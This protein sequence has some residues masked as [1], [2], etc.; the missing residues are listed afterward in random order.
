MKGTIKLQ[1]LLGT[2]IFIT[3]SSLQDQPPS[4]LAKIKIWS[5]EAKESHQYH[6][7]KRSRQKRAWIVDAFEIQEELPGPYPKLIGTVNLEDGV[8]LR[9]K[10]QGKGINEEPKGL[11]HINED[12]GN[13]YVHD[14][15]DYEATPIFNW[16]F[17]AINRTSNKLG[18][19][20]GIQ[21][22]VI[23]INDNAPEFSSSSYEV[24]VNESCMQGFT[25]FTLL[26]YDKDDHFS[27]NSL[28]HYTI[29]SQVPTDPDVEFTVHKEKGFISFKGCL[30]YVR[31]KH[32]KL[33]FEAKDNGVAIQQRSQCEVIINIIDRN[34]NPPFWESESGQTEISEREENITVIRLAVTDKDTPHTPA[35]TAV[36]SIIEGNE[37]GNFKIETDPVT[38]EGILTVIKALDY[39]KT[40]QNNLSITVANL[41]PLFSCK[42]V[43]RTLAGLW[44]VDAAKNI[45]TRTLTPMKGVSVKV[46]DTNDPPQFISEKIAYNIVEHSLKPGSPVGTIQAKDLD[47]VSPNKIKYVILNDPANWV[48]VN[49]DTGVITCT[50]DMDR[51]SEFVYNSKYNVTIL[52]V[53]DGVPSM[54]GTATFI[55]N[56]KDIN[57][58]TPTL[59]SPYMTLCES[60]EEVLMSTP[61]IDRDL[62][63]YSGPFYIEALD[64]ATEKKHLKLLENNGN[65][66]KVLKLKDAPRGNHTLHLEIYDRQG[67]ISHQNLTVFVCECLEGGVCLEKMNG[68]PGLGGGAIALLLLVPVLF[69]GL[70]LLLCKI[71][72]AKVMVPVEQEP[73][74]SFIAYNE[75]SGNRDC[76]ATPVVMENS[77]AHFGQGV[78]GEG[79]M[80]AAGEEIDA[81]FHRSSTRKYSAPAVMM[82]KKNMLAHSNTQQYQFH[83]QRSLRQTT[84]TPKNR[85]SVRRHSSFHGE[86]RERRASSHTLRH[87]AGA[88]QRRSTATNSSSIRNDAINSSF[89]RSYHSRILESLIKQ[90]LDSYVDDELVTYKPR[91][92]MLEGD[93]SPAPS[94]EAISIGSS[95]ITLERLENLDSKFNILENICAKQMHQGFME[96]HS[97]LQ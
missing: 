9:Y 62:D 13:I 63:P 96:E 4:P 80:A 61:I 53:D 19:K 7:L 82:V 87:M 64:K 35:W 97:M 15:I 30:D 88:G 29:L 18:T 51:E 75:E 91:V 79:S 44:V 21:L 20:L 36:Y 66:L 10:L 68:P 92:Y 69:L 39:E 28:V 70:S 78:K 46:K 84:G 81:V 93:L 32:Y 27:P 52:A 76:Q 26:A 2:L 6:H 3:G 24:P 65:I 12:N 14:K 71:Q 95:S 41:E 58:N 40:S 17:H 38:N 16:E 59:E 34:N 5:A 89:R 48:D 11:F 23:D 90:K 77:S 56:L 67:E 1:I 8:Q 31:N 85:S 42:V 47:I 72:R 49:E 86:R 22:K 37:D 74:H 33:K 43:E 83:R 94:L 57:D 73:L 45:K 50:Q 60:E 55:I 25:V 54:T